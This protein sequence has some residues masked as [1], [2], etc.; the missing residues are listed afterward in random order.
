MTASTAEKI[1]ESFPHPTIFLIIGQPTR[2][3]IATVYLH[4]NADAASVH[5]HRGNLQLGLL[6]LTLQAEV[7][8]TFSNV[9]CLPLINP[10]QY[11]GIPEV[12]TGSASASIRKEHEDKFK[13]FLIYD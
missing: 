8:N 7:F 5:S 6:H 13:E 1:L 4:L 2:M 12:F 10:G 11:P 9:E 3:T